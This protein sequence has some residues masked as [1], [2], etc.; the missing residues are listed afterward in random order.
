MNIEGASF[1]FQK[2]YTQGAEPGI[3]TVKQFAVS[4]QQ[5]NALSSYTNNTLKSDD[6]NMAILKGVARQM[7]HGIGSTP[8]QQQ[9][10]KEFLVELKAIEHGKFGEVERELE[11]MGARFG[12]NPVRTK[13][14]VGFGELNQAVAKSYSEA[15][16]IINAEASKL[17]VAEASITKLEKEID[18]QQRL[19]GL[20]TGD[21]PEAKKFVLGKYRAEPTQL[22][23]LASQIKEDIGAAQEE[24]KA[25]K[26]AAADS[27]IVIETLTG[28]REQGLAQ[29]VPI[30]EQ[31]LAITPINPQEIANK[32][33]TPATVAEVPPTLVAEQTSRPD[34]GFMTRD[35]IMTKEGEIKF[36]TA[37]IQESERLLEQMPPEKRQ[38]IEEKTSVL[39]SLSARKARL[40]SVR[41]MERYT[42]KTDAVPG[43]NPIVAA[44][45]FIGN[46]T[47]IADSIQGR[48]PEQ[49]RAR[50]GDAFN[51]LSGTELPAQ[52]RGISGS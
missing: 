15:E 18:V 27:R 30:A 7:I 17:T 33:E 2:G 3:E 22:E 52:T 42:P 8:K 29:R 45:E 40:N 5:K 47:S 16:Q 26:L 21:N 50:I 10:G 25:V 11:G 32:Q 49:N 19:L 28:A 13:A 24:L 43:S 14:D 37:F 39:K 31:R 4:A 12:S 35:E 46:Y 38:S 23:A 9:I 51:E 41:T 48:T 20:L 1:N 34:I 36:L 44:A 6:V